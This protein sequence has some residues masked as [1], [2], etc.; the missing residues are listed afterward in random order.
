MKQKL[1]KYA[2]TLA[3]GLLIALAVSF[4]RSLYWLTNAKDIIMTICDCFTVAGAVLVCFGLLIFCSNGGTFDMLS[5]GMLKVVGLFKR[6]P[7]KEDRQTFHEY[8]EAKQGN[9]RSFGY[10][11]FCGLFYCAVAVVFLIIYYNI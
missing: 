3:V 4:V 9:K 11:V 2:I 5:F 10:I 1:V 7:G 8:R 6:N